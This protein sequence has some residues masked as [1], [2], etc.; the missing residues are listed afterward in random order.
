MRFAKLRWLLSTIV[1]L[2]CSC[3]NAQEQFV[4]RVKAIDKDTSFLREQ[5]NLQTTFPT[6]AEGLIY[7]SKILPALQSKGY[8]T[9]SIDTLIHD[10]SSSYLVLFAGDV[11]K[12]ESLSLSGA[13]QVMM[14]AM[15]WRDVLFTNQSLDVAQIQNWHDRMLDYLEDNGYPFGKVYIDSMRING[16]SVSGI[17]KIEKGPQYKID[18]IRVFGDVKVSNRFLQ[19]YLE[20]ED[21][22]LYNK[23][24]LERISRRLA[25]LPYLEEERRSNLSMLGTGSVLNLYLKPR[26]SSQINVLVG[27]LPNNDQLSSKK[28]LVTGEANIQLRNSLGAGESI[29]LNWQQIQVK[30]PRLN[31][32]YQHPYVFD[33]PIGLDFSFNMFRKDSTFLN[34]NLQFG[35]QYIL[36]ANQSGRLFLQRFQTILNGINQQFIIQNRRLPDA[37]DVSSL[38]LGLDYDFNNTNYRFNPRSGNE[39]RVITSVGTKKIKKNNEVLSL[40]DPGDPSFDFDRLYDTLKLKT[41]QF[42][43]SLRAAKF[44][45]TGR[46]GTFLTAINGGVYQ[47][48][49][50]FRN[51]LFQIGGYKLLRGFD[52]ESQYLSQYFLGTL[53]YRILINRDSYFN[54]F[55]DGGWGRDNSQRRNENHTYIGGGMGIAFSM[56]AGIFNL[57][58]AN[59]KRNDLPFNLRQT[60]IHLGFINFF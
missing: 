30:S 12:W 20:I 34:V 47:S 29:G 3:L 13:E 52:E 4:L 18:S 39:F 23:T 5:I 57:A 10:S 43:A 60:K 45:P 53:E 35:A 32:F 37:A 44:F 16:N 40:K 56:R 26:K 6:R 42:R 15:G 48:G 22:S 31:F 55:T 38:N 11:F 46:S 25:E 9:A 19:R 1:F 49:N 54:V 58:L 41:Y 59:G 36:S 50:V 27:F 28:L 21:G 17:I 24:K 8:V 51:E 7:I 2:F 33:S 14:D